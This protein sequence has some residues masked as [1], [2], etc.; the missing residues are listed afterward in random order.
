MY[1]VAFLSNN[2]DF[3]ESFKA[4]VTHMTV[5]EL[6]FLFFTRSENLKTYMAQFGQPDLLLYDKKTD[7]L[8]IT[9]AN[10]LI[11]GL[12]VQSLNVEEGQIS[13][14]QSTQ[15]FIQEI[16]RLL[17]YQINSTNLGEDQLRKKRLWIFDPTEGDWSKQ[18]FNTLVN[19]GFESGKKVICIDLSVLG[20]RYL[21]LSEH[22]LKSLSERLMNFYGLKTNESGESSSGNFSY[23]TAVAH[24]MDL[25]TLTSAFVDQSYAKQA[26]C[27]DHQIAYTGLLSEDVVKS[28]V[29]NFDMVYLLSSEAT[30]YLPRLIQMKS[31]LG[32]INPKLEVHI[33]LATKING[34]D[35]VLVNEMV[36]R[37]GL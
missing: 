9:Y 36:V 26:D 23:I 15:S 24:P 37:L 3:I 17:N 35:E 16:K 21:S 34:Q 2:Y 12:L 20:N 6:K 32:Q 1:A 18:C 31:W 5:D 14:Y 4:S 8:E 30:D 11:S 33:A 25:L 27:F 22:H 10:S 13:I 29:R 7:F 19:K 28:M